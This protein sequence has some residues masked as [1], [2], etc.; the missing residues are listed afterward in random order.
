MIF[1]R[2]TRRIRGEF[3]KNTGRM[4]NSLRILEKNIVCNGAFKIEIGIPTLNSGLLK[5]YM[6]FL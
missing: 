3:N 6:V 1:Y 5:I 2:N 4:Q